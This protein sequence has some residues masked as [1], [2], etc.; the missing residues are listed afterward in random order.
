MVTMGFLLIIGQKRNSFI[1]AKKEDISILT[2]RKLIIQ[3]KKKL[4]FFEKKRFFFFFCMGPSQ[5]GQNLVLRKINGKPNIKFGIFAKKV[6]ICDNLKKKKKKKKKT[7][8]RIIKK[9]KNLFLRCY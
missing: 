2:R 6:E 9:K 7:K 4:N 8:F 3:K 5:H 1:F